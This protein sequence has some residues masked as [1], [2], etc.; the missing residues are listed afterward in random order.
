MSP[1]NMS[2]LSDL[3]DKW[4]SIKKTQSTSIVNVPIDFIDDLVYELVTVN[5]KQEISRLTN[6]K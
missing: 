1:I 4:K 5:L 2:K 3:V 6:P